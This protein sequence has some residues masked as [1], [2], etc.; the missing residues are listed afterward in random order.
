[1]RKAGEKPRE[2]GDIEPPLY[3]PG[4]IPK[5][6]DLFR[7]A[8]FDQALDLGAGVTATFRPAGHILG[9]AF[10]EIDTPDGRVIASATSAIGRAP[11]RTSPF[12]LGSATRS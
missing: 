5:T 4:D 3:V 10:V 2:V 7:D 1:M 11:F 12:S 9:S 8:K 6:L